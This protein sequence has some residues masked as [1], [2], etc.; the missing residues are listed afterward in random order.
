[1]SVSYLIAFEKNLNKTNYLLPENEFTFN[2]YIYQF[3]NY[4]QKLV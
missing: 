4:K 1:M 2:N 3:V